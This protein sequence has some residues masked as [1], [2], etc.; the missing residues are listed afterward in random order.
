MH[1]SEM[2]EQVEE[3]DVQLLPVKRVYI[4]KENGKFRPLG[5]LQLFMIEFAKPF[6]KWQWNR[7][8]TF[9]LNVTPMVAVQRI[10]PAYSTKDAI[11]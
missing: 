1:I 7:N 8:G 9:N 4:S 6:I 3:S 5:I 10:R 2:K 11:E